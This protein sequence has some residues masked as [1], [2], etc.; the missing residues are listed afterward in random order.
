MTN[1]SDLAKK[2]NSIVF[3]L[4]PE[5]RDVVA[6]ILYHGVAGDPKGPRR[7]AESV[8]QKLR[9]DL[10]RFDISIEKP[11]PRSIG[12]AIIIREQDHA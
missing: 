3:T 4:T 6:C 8:L 7:H 12:S 11:T 1:P 9:G 10:R 5:E 2:R